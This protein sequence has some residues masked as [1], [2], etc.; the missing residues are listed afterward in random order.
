MFFRYKAHMVDLHKIQLSIN[1]GK[2]TK[3]EGIEQLRRALVYSMR[4]GDR[5]VINCGKLNIDLKMFNDPVNFPV[6]LIFD[7][8]EWRKDEV[9][10]RIVR[11]EEDVDLMGNKK[12][13][14]MNDTFDII[15]LRD[16]TTDTT[17][18]DAREEFKS[19][20]PHISSFECMFVSREGSKEDQ[21]KEKAK[22]TAF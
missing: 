15:I 16:I 8:N 17:E 5:Y 19:K 11:E 21:I 14:W 9:Y 22:A 3:D 1:L 7:F 20:I 18:K 2:I 6:D 13:Y 4:I 10:K 12:C